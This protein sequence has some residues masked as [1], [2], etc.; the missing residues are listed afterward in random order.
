MRKLLPSSEYFSNNIQ[1]FWVILACTAAHAFKGTGKNIT[2]LYYN[3]F[4][5]FLS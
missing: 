5:F 2:A 3:S 4:Y 1:M